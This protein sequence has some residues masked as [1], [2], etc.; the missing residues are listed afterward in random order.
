[1]LFTSLH[2]VV[3]LLTA[4]AVY[5]VLPAPWRRWMMLAASI[6][7][8][9]SWSVK[10]LA[11]IGLQI[12][13]DW[14]CGFLLSR[15]SAPTRRKLIVAASILVNLTS[16][17][18]FKYYGFFARSLGALGLNVPIVELT[19]PLG[20]SFY[21]FESMSYTIDVYRGRLK[22]VRSP[23]HL[24][25]FIT[26]FPHLIAGPIIRPSEFVPQLEKQTDV[27]RERFISGMSLLMMGYAK[28]LLVADWL[29]KV[30]EPVFASPHDYTGLELLVGV[31]AYAFQIYCD[32][33]AYTDI[34]R[35][36]SR[37]FGIEL[38]ENFNAP[39]LATSITDF[40]RRWHMTLSHWLRDYL[41][42]PLG[43]NR[44]G[45]ARTYINL[46]I[47]MLLG[48]LWHGAN[49]TFVA[50]GGLHGAYLAVERLFGVRGD[51]QA[52]GLKRIARQVLTFHFVC[53][54]WIFF[55]ATSFDAAFE[56]L[57]G[58]FTGGFVI[59]R[60]HLLPI[61][62]ALAVIGGYWTLAPLRP[63]VE[64]FDPGDSIVRQLGFAVAIGVF[65]VGLT[66]LGATTSAFIYFQF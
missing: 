47:T 28:K 10:F 62:G 22:P 44:H 40:W 39:Y 31:Y 52:T 53:L 51:E 17:C 9:A 59:A 15:T 2:W 43:G 18:V 11:L 58:I 46:I 38:P 30:V 56:M 54:A 66:V 19:L 13:T 57:R 5:H 33:S 63:R 60:P 6:Y 27:T 48:G 4:F 21:T 29:A 7:F 3:F 65:F 23:L 55:R 32:F 42:I 45:N 16:L 41:Y 50:W 12:L 14:T 26:W 25:L 24:A 8:Y 1:V 64:A 49:W 61:L 36:A 37:W 35:G 20:I 34:A